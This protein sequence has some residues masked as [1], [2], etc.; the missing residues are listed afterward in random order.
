M[1]NVGKIAV[2]GLGSMILVVG[3]SYGLAKIGIIPVKNLAK[4][5]KMAASSLHAIGL[6]NAPKSK[7]A[8]AV[9]VDPLAEQKKDL[10][11]QKAAL[12]AERT[13][14]QN[15]AATHV[16]L[17]ASAAPATAPL[18]PKELARM[19]SV[20]EQMPADTASKIFAKLPDDQVIALLRKMDEKKV[21]EIL[22][23]A[24]PERAARLT[25][26][27]SRAPAPTPDHATNTL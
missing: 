23:I 8:A 16:K 24:T 1:A 10:N 14:L 25:M 15:Q 20:Y 9:A 17:A 4:H 12:D 22:A 26:N 13:A 3:A 6:Y 7:P 18:D 19:A 21:G 27:L 2:I 5:N 11:D